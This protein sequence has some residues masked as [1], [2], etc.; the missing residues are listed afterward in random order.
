MAVTRKR[1]G[2]GTGQ[3]RDEGGARALKE[4]SPNMRKLGYSIE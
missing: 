3:R 2:A 4:G 1:T